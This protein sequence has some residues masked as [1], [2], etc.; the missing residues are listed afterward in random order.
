M[1][2]TFRA[3]EQLSKQ[4]INQKQ[5]KKKVNDALTLFLFLCVLFR[6]V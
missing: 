4:H 2:L 5:L 3:A 6:Q 1:S